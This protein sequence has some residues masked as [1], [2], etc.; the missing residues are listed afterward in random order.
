[1][2]LSSTPITR[3]ILIS[4]RPE[5]ARWLKGSSTDPRPLSMFS[6][7]STPL[8][9]QS[10]VSAGIL[11]R[12][13]HSSLPFCGEGLAN[14]AMDMSF[15]ASRDSSLSN[16][17]CSTSCRRVFS[18]VDVVCCHQHPSLA[19]VRSLSAKSLHDGPPIPPTHNASQQL[20]NQVA[21]RHHFLHS[22]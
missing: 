6:Q 4:A 3:R 18:C 13:H 20:Y 2:K 16:I 10:R 17:C 8:A 14:K 1:M 7:A 12:F 5:Q 15:V 11:R 9:S 21:V 22:Y 19:E